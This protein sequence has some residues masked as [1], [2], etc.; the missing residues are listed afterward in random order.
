TESNQYLARA[1]S[2]LKA[3]NADIRAYAAELNLSQKALRQLNQQLETR[4]AERTSQLQAALREAEQQRATIAAVFDQTPTAVCLLRG[5]ELRFEYVNDSY[6]RFYPEKEL[7]GRPLAEALPNVDEQGFIA[8]LQQVYATGQPYHGQEM[9]LVDAGPLGPRT[10]Y[11]DFTYQAYREY[12]IVA[13]VAVC[14]FDVSEQVRVREQV[15]MAIFRGPR[16]VIE[17]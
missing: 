6:Q 9:P 5:P 2:D 10:R 16:Y 12:G 17:L 15:A 4:V 8:L 13:G 7:L 3:A 1:N 14:A 11:F